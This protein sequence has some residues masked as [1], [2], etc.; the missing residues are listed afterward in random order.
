MYIII[1]SAD[2]PNNMYRVLKID[3]DVPNYGIY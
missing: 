2:D 1:Y 3:I